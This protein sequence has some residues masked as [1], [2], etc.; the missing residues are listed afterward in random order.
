[1]AQERWVSTPPKGIPMCAIGVDCSGGADDPMV[2]ARRHDGWFA[3]LIE[4]PG[5]SIPAERAGAHCAG[6]VLSYR[7]DNAEV[8]IDMGGGYGGPL[9]EQ[10]AANKIEAQRYKGAEAATRR[11]SDGSLGFTNTRS[12]AIWMLREAL[13]PSQPG[14]S[15]IAFPPD[16]KLMADLTA[17]TFKVTPRGIQVESKEDVCKRL[18]RSTDHGDSAAMSWV[19]GPRAL[20]H[21][22]EWLDQRHDGMANVVHSKRKVAR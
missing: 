5:K 4:V 19:C 20:T 1:M 7:R 21:T 15:P 13:D 3:P 14:G 11:T 8:I 6:I 18:G 17:P 16:Q 9:Y 12:A 2:L 22:L 10:L